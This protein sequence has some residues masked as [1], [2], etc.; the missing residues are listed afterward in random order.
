MYRGLLI[1]KPVSEEKHDISSEHSKSMYRTRETAAGVP[2][3]S[4]QFLR[5]EGGR[6]WITLELC[7]AACCRKRQGWGLAGSMHQR[8]VSCRSLSHGPRIGVGGKSFTLRENALLFTGPQNGCHGWLCIGPR[9]GVKG[10]LRSMSKE[11]AAVLT[12]FFRAQTCEG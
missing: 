5:S 7:V 10:S 4:S 3:S 1:Q 2:E 12:E 11:A 6:L 9:C 8:N